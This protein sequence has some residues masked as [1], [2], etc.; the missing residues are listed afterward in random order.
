MRAK[1]ARD[2]LVEGYLPVVIALAKKYARHAR[3]MEMLDLIQEGNAALLQAVDRTQTYNPCRFTMFVLKY[4]RGAILQVLRESNGHVRVP[5][6]V[7]EDLRKLGGVEWEMEAAL[8]RFPGVCELAAEM[9]V[10]TQRVQEMREWRR[11]VE[12]ESLQGLA[13]EDEDFEGRHVLTNVCQSSGVPG[14][15]L[16]EEIEQGIRQAIETVLTEKQK[17]V[18]ELRYGSDRVL[19]LKT[20]GEILGKADET[21]KKHEV[22]ALKKLRVALAS[23]AIGA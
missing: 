3:G 2:R 18:I 11:C 10:S 17:E 20:V 4:V 13:Y 14:S 7:A 1:Y 21:V 12:A 8:G 9:G 6:N 5:S 15:A 16:G 23:L 19:Q 22:Y